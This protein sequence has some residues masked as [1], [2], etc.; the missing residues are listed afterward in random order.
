MST[1]VEGWCY[2]AAPKQEHPMPEALINDIKQRLDQLRSQEPLTTEGNGKSRLIPIVT[3]RND[4][5]DQ[6]SISDQEPKSEIGN[7]SF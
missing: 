4:N 3:R 5:R 6:E 1:T 7:Y 2:A